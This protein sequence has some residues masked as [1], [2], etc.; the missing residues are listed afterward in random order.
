[1]RS[2]RAEC[3]N[4][5]RTRRMDDPL[6]WEI[7]SGSRSEAPE[8]PDQLNVLEQLLQSFPA[9]EIKRFAMLY[10]KFMKQLYHWNVWALAYAARGGCSDDAF[11]PFRTW[12]I[13]QGDPALLELA[14]KEPAAAAARVP[15][16][17]GLPEGTLLPMIDEIHLAR[18]GKTFEWPMTDLERPKGKEWPEEELEARYPELV[19]H[20]E[21]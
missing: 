7:V 14:I 13:L 12:L 5:R 15:R 16:D 21:A 19:A 3:R 2:G 10:G 6:F 4:C 20:Y 8:L 17:L 11:I 9:P 1:M 18:A